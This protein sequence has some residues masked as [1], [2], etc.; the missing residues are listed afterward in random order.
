[1]ASDPFIDRVSDK[2]LKANGLRPNR[3]IK[4]EAKNGKD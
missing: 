1:M 4:G 3:T 2:A